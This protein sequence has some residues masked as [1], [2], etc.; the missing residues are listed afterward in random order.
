MT[1]RGRTPPGHGVL[2]ADPSEGRIAAAVTRAALQRLPVSSQRAGCLAGNACPT[3][4]R[5]GAPDYHERSAPSTQTV[6]S[7]FQRI[8]WT[9][10]LSGCEL[11]ATWLPGCRSEAS[12][13][14][15]VKLDYVGQ[16]ETLARERS[17]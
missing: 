3:Y 10:R 17:A 6:A 1:I 15:R 11:C 9:T 8:D 13:A 7:S 4:G 16:F 5:H 2:T 14:I 12:Y